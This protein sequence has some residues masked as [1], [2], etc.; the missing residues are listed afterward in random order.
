MSASASTGSKKHGRGGDTCICAGCNTGHGSSPATC[1]MFWDNKCYVRQ[2]MRL[3]DGARIADVTP[4]SLHRNSCFM[5]E[6]GKVVT[7]RSVAA[8]LSKAV[9]VAGVAIAMASK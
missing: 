2:V 9:V 6:V 3:Y 1:T 4:L 7:V 8:R 5:K